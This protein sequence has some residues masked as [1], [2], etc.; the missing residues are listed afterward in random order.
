MFFNLL[1]FQTPDHLFFSCFDSS[2]LEYRGVRGRFLGECSDYRV[3]ETGFLE[4]FSYRR[5][6]RSIDRI[7]RQ[8]WRSDTVPLITKK[9]KRINLFTKA[10]QIEINRARA[11]RELP[12][13]SLV[14]GKQLGFVEPDQSSNAN[15]SDP[16]EPR[17]TESD[18]AQLVRKSGSKRKEREGVSSEE[19]QA[20]ETSTGGAPDRRR[21]GRARIPLRFG[22][23]LWRE[24][25][26]RPWSLATILEMTFSRIRLSMVVFRGLLLR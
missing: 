9:S 3:P 24:V 1:L 15:S 25:S 12:D 11:M 4:N 8:V 22:L 6:R 20:E 13:L 17:A 10:E 5:I 18:G 7:K 2:S 23:P 14:V 21:S 19:K 26:S 16:G